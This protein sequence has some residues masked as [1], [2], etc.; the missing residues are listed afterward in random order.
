MSLSVIVERVA[1]PEPIVGFRTFRVRRY[2]FGVGISRRR[3]RGW[4]DARRDR[5]REH[6]ARRL[7]DV[8]LAGHTRALLAA[9]SR[10]WRAAGREHS[11]RSAPKYASDARSV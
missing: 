7:A 8:K 2:G 4:R 3:L 6:R 10:A 1:P 5:A 9:A 11:T